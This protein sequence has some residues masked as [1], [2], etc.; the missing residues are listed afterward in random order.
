MD[1]VTIVFSYITANN[2]IMDK[3]DPKEE[4]KILHGDLT[5]LL[6]YTPD[7]NESIK[8]YGDR[9]NILVMPKSDNTIN[10]ISTKPQLKK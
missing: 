5:V 10:V 8:V 3:E 4:I 7:G 9:G 1:F 2:N 6:T